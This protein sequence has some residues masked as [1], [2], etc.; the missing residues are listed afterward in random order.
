MRLIKMTG[1]LGNQM[2]I[3]AFFVSMKRRFPSTRIDLSDMVHYHAHHGYELHRIFDLPHDEFCINQ[4]VK[5]VVEFLFFKTIL[6]RKQDQITLRAFWRKRLWP[7]I[8]FKGFYQSERYFA[9]CADNVRRLFTFDEQRANHR[10]RQ[11]LTQLQNDPDA[12]SLHVRRGDYLDPSVWR[13]T[14]CVCTLDYYRDAIQAIRQHVDKPRFYVFSDDIAWVR[15]NLP[16][17]GA[18]YVDWNHGT[19]SWQ[20]MLLMSRC[21]HHVI[22]NSTFSWWGAWLNPRA[23]KVVIAPARWS[24]LGEMPYICPENWMQIPVRPADLSP[25]P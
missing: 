14:G 2:F 21:R 1:G 15:E 4:K 25:Q 13:N 12:V 10:T 24:A 5:K 20:D 22:C 8:Y 11:L 6:E 16:L 18:T 7:L 19:D 17:D 23:D 9:D 3:Y